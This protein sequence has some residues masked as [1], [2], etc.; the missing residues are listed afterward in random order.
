MN[1]HYRIGQGS[2][3]VTSGEATNALARENFRKTLSL[4]LSGTSPL[5]LLVSVWPM[6]QSLSD[7]SQFVSADPFL[8][9]GQALGGTQQFRRI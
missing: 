1:F 2:G 4:L 5:L 3:M 9:F 7:E 8:Y 6:F